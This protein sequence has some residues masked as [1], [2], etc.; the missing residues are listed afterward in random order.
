MTGTR[1]RGS[2]GLVRAVFPAGVVPQPPPQTGI[3]EVVDALDVEAWAIEHEVTRDGHECDDLVLRYCGETKPAAY[4]PQCR[5]LVSARD[6]P[7]SDAAPL[8]AEPTHFETA[9]LVLRANV[10]TAALLAIMTWL[11]SLGFTAPGLGFLLAVAALALY[12][13]AVRD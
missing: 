3:V 5:V 8:L 12:A 7:E 13:R 11:A 4:C 2:D 10:G 6:W 9:L 1:D